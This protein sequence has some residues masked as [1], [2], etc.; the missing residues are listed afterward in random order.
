MIPR[1]RDGYLNKLIEAMDAPVIKVISGVRRCGKSTLFDIFEAYLVSVGIEKERIVRIDMDTKEMK[2]RV[3]NWSEMYDAVEKRMKKGVRNYVLLDEVQNIADWESALISMYTD[4]DADLYVTGSNAVMLSPNLGTKLVG[5]FIEIRMLPL[6]FKE[7]MDFTDS[8]DKERSFAEYMRIGGFPSVALLSDRPALQRDM[9]SGIYSTVLYLDIVEK[10]GIRDIALL[11]SL[12]EFMIE[13]VGNTVSAKSISDYLNSSGRKSNHNTIEDYLLIMERAFL[14]Y[15]VR[16]YDITGKLRL[17]TLG[18]YY[19][20]DPGLRNLIGGR[21]DGSGRI[22][23]NMVYLELL[24]RGYDISIGK[25][26]AYEVDFIA[27]RHGDRM[28]VQVAMTMSD[29]AVA[30]RELRP[31]MNIEDNHPKMIISMDPEMPGDY[32]GIKSR[33]LV[34]WLLEE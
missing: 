16:R 25:I 12:T 28:Y 22:L 14:L 5:R 21:Q 30:E 24:R 20:V 18:K 13:N 31:L 10:N 7:Y 1:A 6:S 15:R 26:G 23:E 2:E 3:S 33:N 27:D 11:K 34:E 9:L 29:K 4:L 19:V 32:S 17:K 8:R